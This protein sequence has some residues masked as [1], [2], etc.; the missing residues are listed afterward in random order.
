MEARESAISWRPT[1]RLG[2]RGL[3]AKNALAEA[4]T[5]VELSKSSSIAAMLEYGLVRSVNTELSTSA[6]IIAVPNPARVSAVPWM[7]TFTVIMSETAV[8][9]MPQ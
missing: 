2:G 4:C 8:M 9:A 3:I 1:F 7:F 5:R 6:R